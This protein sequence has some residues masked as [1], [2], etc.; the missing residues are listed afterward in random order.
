LKQRL[1]SPV[2]DQFEAEE[3]IGDLI[4]DVDSGARSATQL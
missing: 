2:F 1:L 3:K 4:I